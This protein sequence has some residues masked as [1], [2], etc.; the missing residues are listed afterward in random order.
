MT[1]KIEA[2]HIAF[3]WMLPKK[4]PNL[5]ASTH[6]I[7]AAKLKIAISIAYEV[8]NTRADLAEKYPAFIIYNS[9]RHICRI[10]RETRYSNTNHVLRCQVYGW[11]NGCCNLSNPMSV[12]EGKVFM[13]TE[14]ALYRFNEFDGINT[15]ESESLKIKFKTSEQLDCFWVYIFVK[16]E[17]AASFRYYKCHML[18]HVFV[19]LKD[20]INAGGL[21][22]VK[23]PGHFY[24]F[25][26]ILENLME[27]KSCYPVNLP[28]ELYLGSTK[29]IVLIKKIKSAEVKVL[30]DLNKDKD[31]YEFADKKLRD[32]F[33]ELGEIG[34]CHLL[35]KKYDVRTATILSEYTKKFWAEQTLYHC[36]M[37]F[38]IESNDS[39]S[40]RYYIKTKNWQRK[41]YCNDICHLLML[42]GY[43]RLWY[44]EKNMPATS[45]CK[46]FMLCCHKEERSHTVLLRGKA[47]M[48]LYK[49]EIKKYSNALK[50]RKLCE[51]GSAEYH[52]WDGIQYGSVVRKLENHSVRAK[53]NPFITKDRMYNAIMHASRMSSL[54]NQ[55]KHINSKIYNAFENMMP[56]IKKTFNKLSY[57]ETLTKNIDEVAKSAVIIDKKKNILPRL[58]ESLKN[59]LNFRRDLCA[60]STTHNECRAENPERWEKPKK[61]FRIRAYLGKEEVSVN[62]DNV[63]DIL[64]NYEADVS[65]KIKRMKDEKPLIGDE[66]AINQLITAQIIYNKNQKHKKMR[67]AREYNTETLKKK[68]NEFKVSDKSARIADLGRKKRLK[69]NNSKIDKIKKMRKKGLISKYELDSNH[70]QQFRSKK[71]CRIKPYVK[72]YHL[73]KMANQTL[74]FQTLFPKIEVLDVHD[75]RG[76]WKWPEFNLPKCITSDKRDY[77]M[78]LN[79]EELLEYNR[80]RNKIRRKEKKIRDKAKRALTRDER[81]EKERK[82]VE[83]ETE[84][85]GSFL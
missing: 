37:K 80:E 50:R 59:C 8:L 13:M 55:Y 44:Y 43:P 54:D 53:L 45:A 32:I 57:L 81:I 42:S 75:E 34:L 2:L 29:E 51:V 74:E 72:R 40:I 48:D 36:A 64:E 65:E 49:K 63:F 7:T 21:Y 85:W 46:P 1:K 83:I 12:H 67:I 14:Q 61:P 23:S 58:E 38:L 16:N 39:I 26:E 82:R 27:G 20:L 11:V 78:Y 70:R 9:W 76:E 60:F 35:S 66:T 3:N 24:S 62:T 28:P 41:R 47:Q 84:F 22:C 6:P 56:T 33:E 73:Y 25:Y 5:Q 18:S 52:K 79:P 10:L 19:N 31:I 71:V 30:E 4:R 15:L 68:I 77:W 69:S 17:Y